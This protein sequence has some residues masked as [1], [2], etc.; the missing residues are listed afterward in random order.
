MRIDIN[1]QSL[2]QKLKHKAI[3]NSLRKGKMN[4]PA[5]PTTTWTWS[6]C[7]QRECARAASRRGPRTQADPRREGAARVWLFC[8]NVLALSSINTTLMRPV[9]TVVPYSDRPLH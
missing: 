6:T 5:R 8:K 1:F 9:P 2:A 7:A 3:S 4:S